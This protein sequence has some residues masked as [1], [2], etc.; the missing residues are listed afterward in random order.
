MGKGIR[1]S[2]HVCEGILQNID[3]YTDAFSLQSIRDRSFQ[4]IWWDCFCSCPSASLWQWLK[5]FA[6]QVKVAS[7]ILSSGREELSSGIYVTPPNLFLQTWCSLPSCNP[8]LS[9]SPPGL[10]QLG[11][12]RATLR[13]PAAGPKPAAGTQATHTVVSLHIFSISAFERLYNSSWILL[14]QLA[15]MY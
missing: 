8:Y 14:I 6:Q 9:Y 15:N 1:G 11:I 12:A 2:S 4:C 5:T 10:Q 13:L 3:Y 7:W